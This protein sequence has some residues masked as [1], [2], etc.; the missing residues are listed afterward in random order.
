MTRDDVI[1]IWDAVRGNLV[2]LSGALLTVQGTVVTLM[3]TGAFNEVMSKAGLIKMGIANTLFGAFLTG[4]G[5][6]NS[7]KVRIAEAMQTAIKASPGELPID[8]KVLAV[9]PE[10]EKIDAKT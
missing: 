4:L 7:A 10:E 1:W 2:K 5:F 8:V 9:K 3:A 6:N